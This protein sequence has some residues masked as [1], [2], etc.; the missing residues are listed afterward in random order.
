MNINM[1]KQIYQAVIQIDNVSA[2]LGTTDDKAQLLTYY[3]HLGI[4][5]SM[6]EFLPVREN[7]YN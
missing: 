3:E 5:P 4:K 7:Q 2:N 6:I 1:E